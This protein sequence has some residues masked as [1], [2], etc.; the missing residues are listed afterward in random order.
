M[1]GT[2][3]HTKGHKHVPAGLLERWYGVEK[4]NHLS[5]CL[6]TF[7]M[8]VP[9]LDAPGKVWVMPGGDFVGSLKAGSEMSALDR[10]MDVLRRHRAAAR[11]RGGR[12]QHGRLNAFA[13]L[14]A[15]IAAATGGKAQYLNFAKTGVAAS[16]TGGTMD[17][18]TRGT[19]PAAGAAGGALPGGTSPTNATTGN[20]GW[21]NPAS[22]NT[23]HL[24]AI[25]ATASIIN[26]SLMLTDRL[27]AAAINPNTTATQSVTGTFA[28][29]QS[30]T[31]T[32]ADYIGGNFIYPSNPTTVL[33]AT[34]HNYDAV[35]YTDQGSTTAQQCPTTTGISA[36]PVGQVDIAV[37]ANSWHLPF[38]SGDVGCKALTQVKLS[39]AV[40][41][42]TMDMVVAHMI[43][44]IGFP[45]ALHVCIA[46]SLY[47][48][49]QLTSV[50]DDACLN[51]ME[52][53]KPATTATTYSGRVSLVA[54]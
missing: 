31:S 52:M 30:G 44:L 21:A 13:S 6:R 41:T 20:L 40:A 17:M 5:E 7:P 16:A 1:D 3:F 19:V 29:Y 10:A 35:Q 12:V 8:P 36:C 22:A 34:A 37:G 38:A 49:L 27:F 43:G 28:R 18:W 53:P 51:F 2:L 45:V 39:A 23:G 33:A 47:T 11:I 50:F 48:A 26:N 42:G 24:L 14:D 4:I 54:E 25:E 46:D 32:A 9:L 15:L